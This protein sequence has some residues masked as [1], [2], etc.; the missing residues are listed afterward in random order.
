MLFLI[1]A[2]GS[3]NTLFSISGGSQENLVVGGAGSIAKRVADDARRRPI[4]L[5]APVRAIR[6]K[7]DHVVVEVARDPSPT[8]ALTVAARHAIVTV[9]PA[10]ALEIEFDPV[11]PPD[12]LTLYRH[13]TAGPETKTLIVYDEPF[14][15]ADGFSGQSADPKSAS[16][17]TIDASP[18][19]GTPGVLASFTFGPVAER[20]DALDAAERRRLVLA[21]MVERFGPRAGTPSAFIETPWWKE[22]WTRGLLD[23]ALVAG[24]PDA[25]RRAAAP[26]VRA[27]ALGGHRDRDHLV[28]RDRRRRPLRRAR[29]RRDHPAVAASLV[30]SR[31]ARRWIVSSFASVA[32]LILATALA[33]GI[34]EMGSRRIDGLPLTTAI[35]PPR[36]PPPPARHLVDLARTLPRAPDVDPAWIDLSPPPLRNR[37][38]VDAEL[39]Q[40]RAAGAGR[41]ELESDLYRQWNALYVDSGCADGGRLWQLPPPLF[42]FDPPEPNPQPIY[43]FPLNVTTPLGLVTNQFGWRGPDIPLTKPARTVRVAFVGASTTVGGHELPFSYP[44]LV[45]HWLNTWAERSG[46]QVRFDGINAGREGL[47]SAS[48]VAIVRQELLVAEPD[49]V[50]YYEGAT[51]SRSPT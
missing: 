35:L 30:M 40:I 37:R 16:E 18:A 27:R 22:E 1:R 25:I 46:R 48:F 6:Q 15:R 11:L 10:L 43:R 41:V 7:A 33:L 3:I 13:S 12:R 14:W 17:V 20:V 26:A 39:L 51:S 9:P 2:H 8:A 44:E 34:A 28:R 21:G 29:G 19:A 36:P 31:A 49:L 38:P 45:V 24:D 42:V 4:R 50:V 47:V 23:G 32:V 5:N